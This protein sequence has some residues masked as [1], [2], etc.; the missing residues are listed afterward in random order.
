MSVDLY[1]PAIAEFRGV[2]TYC[3]HN[4]LDFIKVILPLYR[5][6]L[7]YK[8]TRITERIGQLL[9]GIL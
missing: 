9:P 2:N 4:G 7:R 5:H 8:P 1:N 6:E 3:G